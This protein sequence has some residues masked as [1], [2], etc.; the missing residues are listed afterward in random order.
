[1]KDLKQKHFLI[2]GLSIIMGVLSVIPMERPISIIVLAEIVFYTVFVFVGEYEKADELVESNINKA[3]KIIIILMLVAFVVFHF[4]TLKEVIIPANVFG[5]VAFA[6]IAAKSILFLW[7]D[8][9]VS[10]SEGE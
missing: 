9:T 10:D 5:C 1:M 4:L 8:R 3:N 6:A 2:A 7:F